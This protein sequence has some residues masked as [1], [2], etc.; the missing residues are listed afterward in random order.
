LPDKYPNDGYPKMLISESPLQYLPKLG[1]A[2]GDPGEA[3]LLQQLRLRLAMAT[4]QYDGH[5][6]VFNSYAAWG[7]EM[8]MSTDV[9]RRKLR[10]LRDKG[11][12]VSITNPFNKWDKVLWWRLDR[13]VVTPFLQRANPPDHQ[14][15]P[16]DEEAESPD[17]RAIRLIDKTN[18]PSRQG[19]SAS[20]R[21]EPAF[22][23]PK[24]N[25][26]RRHHETTPQDDT[27]DGRPHRFAALEERVQKRTSDAEASVC[28]HARV[29]GQYC[30]GCKGNRAA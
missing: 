13:D 21:G 28:K 12:V 25:T 29:I 26:I 24:E 23:I 16:P 1:L 30:A 6:W 9:A 3:L 4:K 11:L 8:G 20:G 19:D 27:T 2:L 22:A 17:V 10:R 7:V 14:A 5:Y 15:N 18:P